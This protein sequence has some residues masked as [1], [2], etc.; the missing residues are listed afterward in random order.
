MLITLTFG[1]Q[2]RKILGTILSALLPLLGHAEKQNF[3]PQQ[4]V[5]A[6]DHLHQYPGCVENSLCSVDSGRHARRWSQLT[7]KLLAQKKRDKNFSPIA[8]IEKFRK[9]FG[10]PLDFISRK[11]AMKSFSPMLWESSCN[12][13]RARSKRGPLMIGRS[14]VRSLKKGSGEIIRNHETH[15]VP[16]GEI[17]QPAPILL[18]EIGKKWPEHTQ[19]YGPYNEHPIA[20]MQG[21]LLYVRDMEG[22]Y[23]YLSV[24]PSGLLRV[25]APL[26][27]EQQTP[28][29]IP[30]PIKMQQVLQKYPQYQNYFSGISCKQ[31]T[32]I[33]SHK[34][35]T[36]IQFTTCPS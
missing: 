21:N 1:L 22:I 31:L 13:F 18:V 26:K 9:K 15:S 2:K 35:H 8:D 16:I 5:T 19:Y 28:V 30:C 32:D 7:L 23:Y 17:F 34:S 24:S 10:L 11:V 20:L 25:K 33:Q 29:A 12:S 6:L 3:S 36:M 14:F 4:V 27:L